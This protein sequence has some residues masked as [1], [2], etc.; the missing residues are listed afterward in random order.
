MTALGQGR[1]AAAMVA[2]A[3]ALT[4]TACGGGASSTASAT[5]G[6]GGTTATATATESSGGTAS[7]RSDDTGAGSSTASSTTLAPV[8]GTT[9]DPCLVGSW[10]A[11]A[12]SG[13]VNVGGTSY[14]FTGGAGEKLQIGADGKTS[15]DNSAD[16]PA[17]GT[18]GGHTLTITTSGSVTGTLATA[19]HRATI[20]LSDPSKIVQ[21]VQLDGQTVSMTPAPAQS[22]VNYGCSEGG[23]G[24]TVTA[25]ALSVAYVPA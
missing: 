22:T 19:D 3:T 13:T 11:S 4:L 5:T 12:Y 15:E 10:K 21:T 2:G 23:A 16:A 6:G 24:F 20:T 25:D 9:V 8:T 7:S 17:V 14:T 18:G 1:S